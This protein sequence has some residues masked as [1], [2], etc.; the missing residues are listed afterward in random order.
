MAF[1]ELRKE[2]VFNII[3]YVAGILSLFALIFFVIRWFVGPA[4]FHFEMLADIPHFLQGRITGI[5]DYISKI[6]NLWMIEDGAYRPRL[7][8]FAVQYTDIKIWMFLNKI[9]VP[10]G[11]RWLFT[12]MALF[13]LF[14]AARKI[15][16]NIFNTKNWNYVCLV[17][18]IF[19]Y[20]PQYIAGNYLFLRSAKVLSPAVGV[21]LLA[22]LC[23]ERKN[24][25]VKEII[26]AF[27]CT[28]LITMDEQL[29]AVVVAMMGYGIINFI[30]SKTHKKNIIFSLEVLVLYFIYH[31]LVGKWIFDYFTAGELLVHRHSFMNL[32]K[33]GENVY[34]SLI[35]W[36]RVVMRFCHD[37]NLLFMGLVLFSIFCICV[38]LKEGLVKE[39]LLFLYFIVVSYGF[40]LAIIT[41]HPVIE[42]LEEQPWGVYFI[43]PVYLLIFALYHGIKNLEEIYIKNEKS[44]NKYS[45]LSKE[46][47]DNTGIIKMML[48]FLSVL[49]I[50]MSLA[51]FEKYAYTHLTTAGA[52][53]DCN[54]DG[55]LD[56]ANLKVHGVEKDYFDR[57]IISQEDYE[58]FLEKNN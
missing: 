18:A 41:E 1:M 33:M 37:S 39:A 48:I 46:I 28:I 44:S 56:D 31:T 38:E 51:N 14:L 49:Y 24:N 52:F 25:H 16:I 23:K 12:I 9:G 19:V 7:L 5:K 35:I 57:L 53:Y 30:F 32:T 55:L 26:M 3:L 20:V 22:V 50:V 45:N 10:L 43:L 36:H 11:G 2:K 6:F 17:T 58:K 34:S 27:L 42:T 47:K 15:C 54:I 29:I 4:I 21:F 8:A 40:V 13:I